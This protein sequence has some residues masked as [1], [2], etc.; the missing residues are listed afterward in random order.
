M[1]K[2]LMDLVEK[3]MMVVFYFMVELSIGRILYWSN[4]VWSNLVVVELCKVEFSVGQI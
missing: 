4:F 2:L 3:F 1:I